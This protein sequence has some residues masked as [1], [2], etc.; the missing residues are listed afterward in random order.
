MLGIPHTTFCRWCDLHLDDGF[1]VLNVRRPRPMAVC[2][3]I[4]RRQHDDLV[5]F[6]VERSLDT[7]CLLY[8][9]SEVSNSSISVSISRSFPFASTSF[10]AVTRSCLPDS[11]KTASSTWSE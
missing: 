1:E 5:E 7:E 4:T 9:L 3:P 8:I 2:H 11:N 6:T 10:L